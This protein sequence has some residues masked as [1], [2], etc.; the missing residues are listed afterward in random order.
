MFDVYVSAPPGSGAESGG[1]SPSA[2][3]P[4]GGR[5]QPPTP[6]PR[7]VEAAVTGAG[8]RARAAA[9]CLTEAEPLQGGTTPRRAET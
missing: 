6:V 1:A 2:A 8:R 4:P 9:P 5:R 7:G 3:A